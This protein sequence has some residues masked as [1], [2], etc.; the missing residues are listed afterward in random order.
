MARKKKAIYM[1]STRSEGTPVVAEGCI[2][3]LKNRIYMTSISKNVYLDKLGYIVNK[4]SK[5]YHRINK[6]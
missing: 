5:I 6:M 1:Y 3:T 4:Y 2:M